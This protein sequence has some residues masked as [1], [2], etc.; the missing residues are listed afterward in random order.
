[1]RIAVNTRFLLT[2]KMEGF[3]WFTYETVRRMVAS[4]PKDEFIFFFDRPYDP[5][6]VFGSNVTPV[7]LFPPARHPLLFRIWFNY[8]VTRA[9][10]KYRPNVFFSPDG[11]LSL[12][13]DCP[14]VGAIHDLNFEHYPEDIPLSHSNYLRHYFPKFAQKANH[15]VTVSQFS[16]QDISETYH[17]DDRKITVAY[18]G[19]SEKFHPLTVDEKANSRNRYAN[20]N[21]YFVM[22]GALHP[23]KNNLRLF[24]A[25]DQFKQKT[26]STTQLV[27]VGSP[28]WR[29]RSYRKVLQ[30]QRSKS[31]IHLVGHLPVEALA[32]VVG[33][34]R[35]LLFPSYFEGF[36]IPLVEAM[37]AHCPIVC[38]DVTALP[39]IAGDAA[40]HIDPFSVESMVEALIAVDGDSELRNR[41][42][43]K[44]KARGEFFCWDNTAATIWKVLK[45][46]GEIGKG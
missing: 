42:I 43:E 23:R 24:R 5:R 40:Y 46:V 10:K 28:L 12:K 4:H 41:L 26:A 45:T 25:F 35:S 18:N 9:L 6:F 21:P 2:S 7:V 1:M 33:G 11:Y 27:V 22:V 8:S 19:A 13:T 15:I 34:A 32:K 39:E 29:D 14:Q 30:A 16:K 3:G 36:G 44:G 17:I 37:K 20:G 38:S 31:A